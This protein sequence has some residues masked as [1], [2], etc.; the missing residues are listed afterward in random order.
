[1]KLRRE[2][3]DNIASYKKYRSETL[4]EDEPYKPLTTGFKRSFGRNNQ[5]KITVRHKGAG[6]KKLYRNISFVRK[7]WD[8][9][10]VVKTVEYDPFR[11]AF[12]SL[13]EYPEKKFEYILHVEGL[14]V[15]DKVIA[16]K[17]KKVSLSVGNSTRLK[18]IAVGTVICNVELVPERGGKVAR[19]AG[20]FVEVVSQLGDYTM[21]KMSSGSVMKVKNTCLAT[22]G[23]VSNIPHQNRILY[24]A[25]Q[26]RHRGIRPSV[27]G[28]AMNPVDHPHGGGEGKTGTKRHPVSYTAKLTKG[29][30][31]ANDKRPKRRFITKGRKAKKK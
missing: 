26:N 14:K 9:E 7:F 22:I 19:A 13:I 2:I 25:G 29:K 24:K 8:V 21:I 18:N 12:V 6:A 20:T 1:M 30:K 10:G 31:T 11:T 3:R 16:S 15:G 28:V 4:T 27:R 17:D 5:G 23:Q